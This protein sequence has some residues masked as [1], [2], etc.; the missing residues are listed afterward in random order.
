MRG[1]KIFYRDN[2]D[3]VINSVEGTHKGTVNFEETDV[4]VGMTIIFTS[5]S[6]KRPRKLGFTINRNG[7]IIQTEPKGNEIGFHAI[8]WPSL[9]SIGERQ[10]VD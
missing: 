3:Q 1:F 7:S 2:T 4:L 9:E 8:P 10:D 6:D 5:E